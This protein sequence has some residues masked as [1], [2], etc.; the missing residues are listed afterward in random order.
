SPDPSPP[1][2]SDDVSIS[3]ASTVCSPNSPF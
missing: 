2:D 3:S 1:S